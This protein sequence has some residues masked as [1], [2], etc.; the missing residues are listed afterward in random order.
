NSYYRIAGKTGTAQILK[1]GKYEK[2]YATSF[3]GYFPA[4][5]PKYSAIVLVKNPRGI[6]QYGNSVA[7]PVF[8]D[9]ADNIY[10]RDINLHTA[11]EK[12]KMPEPGVFPTIR[13]GKQDELTMLA[14]EL[15]VSNHT[16]T[17]EEW[18]KT[19]KNGNAIVW[20][21][22]AIVRD[23]VPDVMGMTF[24]DAIYL[25]E[26]TGLRVS[27]EGK[28]RVSDQ[29]ISPGTRISKGARIYLRLS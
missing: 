13:A 25:L 28:G 5:A 10:S 9:I 1:D 12:A 15:G 14:N 20:K 16:A 11:M 27:Y 23:H 4:H 22:N 29:S 8:K 6:Y 17:E 3:V 24:R 2:R 21:K 7:G 19:S 18:I 26:K